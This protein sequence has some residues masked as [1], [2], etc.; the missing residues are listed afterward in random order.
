M[1]LPK[2]ITF[3]G[4]D[5][6][7]PVHELH[8]LAADYPIEWGVLFSPKRQGS[9]RY[10]SLAYVRYLLENRGRLRLAAH[11]CGG[12]SK[13]LLS[14]WTLEPFLFGVIKA[15]DRVQ[16]N[17]AEVIRPSDIVEL[18]RWGVKNFV[19]PIL[20]YRSGNPPLGTGVQWLF[21]A[22]GGAGIEPKAWPQ[23]IWKWQAQ[24]Q[25]KGFAGG[26]G[27]DNVAEH[28]A[29]IGE[30]ETE[31]WIDMESNVRDENDRFSLAKCRAVCEAVYG[32]K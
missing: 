21:D 24:F 30:R 27:P 3:T 9:S 19:E 8:L 25:L 13:E 10:P 2:F 23:S 11:L 15:F 20:Q 18:H 32:S 17:T 16:V 26:L 4:V 28:V 1:N 5:D 22:S 7:V 14:S 29:T 6:L 12:H 31:F